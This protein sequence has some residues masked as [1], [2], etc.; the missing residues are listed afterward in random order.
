[1]NSAPESRTAAIRERSGTKVGPKVRRLIWV[2]LGVYYRVV[3]NADPNDAIAG[4]PTNS[5]ASP[6]PH[7]AFAAESYTSCTKENQ[8]GYGMEKF[9]AKAGCWAH[10]VVLLN[11]VFHTLPGSYGHAASSN[12]S[13]VPALGGRGF[14]SSEVDPVKITAVSPSHFRKLASSCV[15]V[16]E[17]PLL[18]TGVRRYGNHWHVFMDSFMGMY[19]MLEESGH[20]ERS[21]IV[22]LHNSRVNNPSE[23]YK[24][25]QCCVSRS[26]PLKAHVGPWQPIMKLLSPFPIRTAKWLYH[27]PPGTD[28]G[29]ATHGQARCY[30]EVLLG[31]SPTLNFYR[32]EAS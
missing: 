2:L 22:V 16:E 31:T 5:A 6:Q 32:A 4:A 27:S 8:G 1:M 9:R 25:N 21:P 26:D 28:G 12:L 18:V 10:N 30:R 7:E 14:M 19:S 17:R 15:G 23:P 11:R 3:V 13:F 29:G 24:R 20:L